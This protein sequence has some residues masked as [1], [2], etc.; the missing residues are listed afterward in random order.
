[1]SGQSRP[2]SNSRTRIVAV[3]PTLLSAALVLT[4]VLGLASACSRGE[5][6]ASAGP[7][8]GSTSPSTQASAGSDAAATSTATTA[9]SDVVA[10]PSKLLVVV[11]ENHSA[12]DASKG[13]PGLAAVTHR[14]GLATHSYAVTH[15]SLGNYLAIAGGSSF[16]VR[17][18]KPPSDHR[19]T[20][21]SVFGQVLAAG[22]VAKTYAEAMHGTCQATTNGRYA[23]KHNPWP[24]FTAPAEVAGCKR[25]DVPSGTPARGALRDDIAAGTLPTF[26][27][28]I[29]DTC[30]DAHSCSL[31]T[32]DKW[33]HGWLKVLLAGPDFRAGHLA[34]VIT[35]DE[36]DRHAQ[37]R[38]FTAV[39][40]PALHGTVVNTRL[41]HTA[42]SGSVSRLVGARPLR[43]AAKAPDLL[44]AFHL[45]PTP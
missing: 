13:M 25:Y 37:N 20:G 22:K 43:G 27:M 41:D 6:A 3:R 2:H 24:Y 39:L 40:H 36:D 29:P 1:M 10:R 8:C 32:A 23:V 35:F 31:A 42:L 7:T 30:N 21:A 34:V 45:A 12:C 4:L 33:L 11:M 26:S 9:A 38:I 16:G 28:L 18:D 14:Y 5:D 15:P 44:A 17:D 19:L